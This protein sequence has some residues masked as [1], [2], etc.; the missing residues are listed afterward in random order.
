[1]SAETDPL[2]PHVHTDDQAAESAL[3]PSSLAEFGGQ[4]RVSEQLGLV[5]P[6][7][8]H[9]VTTPDHILL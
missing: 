2:D 7:A 6:G 5:I 4:R 1:M 9:R 3:R 8:N